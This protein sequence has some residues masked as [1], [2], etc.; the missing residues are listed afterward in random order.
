[1]TLR[2]SMEC[3]EPESRLT[4]GLSWK[5]GILAGVEGIAALE[6]SLATTINFVS[7]QRRQM[8][9]GDREDA[10]AVEGGAR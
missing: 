9:P 10:K 1:M 8:R 2:V 6:L 7:D 5:K 3:I 4:S